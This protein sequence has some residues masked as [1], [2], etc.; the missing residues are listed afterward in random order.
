[1]TTWSV[2]VLHVPCRSRRTDHS[3]VISHAHRYLFVEIPLTASWAIRHEL[4][5]HYGG[6][7]I[8][9]KH[10]TYP[11]FSRQATGDELTYFVFGTVRNP[12]DEAVSR[13]FKL[14]TDHKGVFSDPARVKSL[15]ADPVDRKKYAFV[16]ANDADFPA[17]FRRY[18]RRPFGGLVDIDSDRY[19]FVIRY[20]TLQEDFSTVLR[21][22]KIQQAR[23]IPVLNKTEG[24]KADWPSYYTHDI[25]RQAQRVFGPFMKK[26]GYEFPPEWEDYRPGYLRDA[27]FRVV[28][29]A[30]S[31][32]L[33]RFRYSNRLLARAVRALRAHLVG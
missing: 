30:R 16:A 29:R 1:M 6:S 18:H 32:Y 28:C 21:R 26:W 9:H 25:R 14:L 27:E 13:Y 7:P 19:D 17:F 3:V 23:P 5:A 31:I 8:L 10:A 20:E 12:L 24:K 4:C 2:S 33:S 11:E 22:L 15:E